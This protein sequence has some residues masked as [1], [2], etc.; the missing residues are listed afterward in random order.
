MQGLKSVHFDNTVE[1]IIC[2]ERIKINRLL[3]EIN[4]QSVLSQKAMSC[5]HLFTWKK[6]LHVRNES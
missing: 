2:S 1:R 4:K 6:N 5:T 3:Q